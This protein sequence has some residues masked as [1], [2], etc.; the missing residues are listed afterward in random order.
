MTP[1]RKPKP[2]PPLRFHNMPLASQGFPGT[3]L[4]SRPPLLRLPP[5]LRQ[6]IF[7]YLLPGPQETFR[8]YLDS[9]SSSISPKCHLHHLSRHSPQCSDRTTPPYL[10]LPRRPARTLSVLRLNKQI[11]GEA[12][13]VLY[14]ENLFHFVGFNYLPVLDFVR[15]LSPEAR[16]A[17]RKVRLTL[18][19]EKG[20]RR[21]E[22]WEILCRV[23]HGEL[24]GLNT[25]VVDPETWI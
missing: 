18:L 23:L 14:S 20:S 17:V 10:H 13:A 3:S 8:F 25:L 1:K 5:E 21:D 24:P 4:T 9:G 2:P 12:L 6:Q 11:Y 19:R 15:H 22:K 16:G 7:R